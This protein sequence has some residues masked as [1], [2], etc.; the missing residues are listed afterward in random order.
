MKDR[1]GVLRGIIATYLCL[2]R[3]K[4]VLSLQK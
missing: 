4:G 1:L 2:A 3:G